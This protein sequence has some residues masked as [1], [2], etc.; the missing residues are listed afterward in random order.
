MTPLGHLLVRRIEAAGPIT[1]A[2]FMAE[3][4]LHPEHGYYATRDPLGAAGDFTTAPEIS[5]MFGEC[6]GLCLAQAW[7]DQGSPSPV[8]LAELGPGRGTLMADM[9]RATRKVP[10]FHTALSVHFVEAS[11]A[12]RAE[13]A[14]RVPDATW[15][16]RVESLPAGPLLVV[17]NEFFDALPIRQFLRQGPLWAERVIGLSQGRLAW[18]LAPP[19]AQPALDPR[20]SDIV[21]G[22]LVETC[23]ALA[24]ILGEIGQNLE[25]HGGVAL[26]I[27]YGGWGLAGDTFQAVSRHA[28]ADPLDRPGEA[29]LTA[30]VDFQA[31]AEAARPAVPTPMT[32]QGAFLERLGIG[33]R[34]QALAQG[35]EGERRAA[36]LAALRRL[37]HP[38]EMGTL[39]KAMA[40]HP[41]SAPPPPGFGP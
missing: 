1:V 40:L 30:H 41:S 28:F 21:E 34:A 32:T 15:H 27:D 17:A 35:L 39:F 36:H 24:P 26:I 31:L 19:S 6:L 22:G 14:K 16:D 37:T 18:G 3:C 7:M 12:L 5:Q 8:L 11:P 20:L 23:P 9:L 10:G 13:Q 25:R 4:L 2:E 38:E 29:D 33:L